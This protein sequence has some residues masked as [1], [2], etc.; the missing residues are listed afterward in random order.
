MLIDRK[1]L[2]KGAQSIL[3]IG[4]G[5]GI[6]SVQSVTGTIPNSST[7]ANLTI[8]DAVDTANTLLFGGNASE[9][10][11]VAFMNFAVR[12]SLAGSTTIQLLRSGSSGV[13]S[14]STVF[15]LEFL[16]GS[17]ASIQQKTISM[18]SGGTTAT[19]TITSVNTAKSIII[20]LGAVSPSGTAG[21]GGDLDSVAEFTFNS[22][23]Q[24]QATRS[25]AINS[26]ITIEYGVAV[27]EFIV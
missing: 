24:I 5:G 20:P 26:P 16:P 8:T 22:S 23:T 4:G 25:S 9:G 15:I 27:V 1:F 14:S 17:I 18:A 6:K 13:S 11:V 10:G 12:W 3:G 2:N 19:T 21:S 7:F